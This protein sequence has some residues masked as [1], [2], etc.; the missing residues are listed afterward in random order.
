MHGLGR[1]LRRKVSCFPLGHDLNRV[2][3]GK[4]KWGSDCQGEILCLY[5]NFPLEYEA[6]LWLV[7]GNE[8]AETLGQEIDMV[9]SPSLAETLGQDIDKDL[10]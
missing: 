5:G 6:F 3:S 10:T 9:L 7:L 1:V 8:S 4:D 2:L